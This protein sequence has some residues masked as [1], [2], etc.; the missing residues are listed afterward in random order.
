MIYLAAVYHTAEYLLY[1]APIFGIL[2]YATYRLVVFFLASKVET[3]RFS[4]G[5]VNEGQPG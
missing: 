1:F 3:G 5:A 2:L 4:G